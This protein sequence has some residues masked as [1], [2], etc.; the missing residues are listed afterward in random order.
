MSFGMWQILDSVI[1][2]LMANPDRKFIY[3]E[4]VR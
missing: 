3:V 1:P 4:Q 2:A